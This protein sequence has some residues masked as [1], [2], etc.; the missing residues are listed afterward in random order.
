MLKR[1]IMIMGI[2]SLIGINSTILA[3]PIDK[4]GSCKADIG[5][6]INNT[7]QDKIIPNN[8]QQTVQPNNS[9]NNRTQLGQPFTPDNIHREPVQEEGNLPYNANCQ[10]GNCINRGDINSSKD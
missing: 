8:L 7:L 9:M 6:G 3:C 2:V 10:F 5:S 4:P 1:I